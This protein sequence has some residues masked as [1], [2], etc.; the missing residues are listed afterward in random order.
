MAHPSLYYIKFLLAQSRD[1]NTRTETHETM[2]GSLMN[3]GLPE[4]GEAEFLV[5]RERFTPPQGFTF[6]NARHQPTVAF[7]R[8]EKIHSLW[9]PTDNERRVLKELLENTRA[10]DRI[11]I[12]LMGRVGS[13]QVAGWITNFFSL[14]PDVTDRM[15]DT[16]RHYFWNT[17]LSGIGEWRE[18]LGADPRN[19]GLLAAY[20]CGPEQAFYRAGA[21]IDPPDPQYPLREGYRQL[22]F[23]LDSLRF[24]PDLSQDMC[25]RSRLLADIKSVYD[26]LYSVDR[27]EQD[28]NR[29]AKEFLMEKY[30]ALYKKWEEMEGTHSGDGT[31]KKRLKAKPEA[32]EETKGDTN[33]PK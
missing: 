15:I 27:G 31:D 6:T 2:S 33:E 29:R 18:R 1:D 32:T 20:L 12:L 24:S 4:V 9:Q 28:R 3:L 16:Y 26:L 25:N 22:S 8:S 11:D 23:L 30:P 5:I 7:M 14:K 10:R 17:D 13:D 19:D 21:N